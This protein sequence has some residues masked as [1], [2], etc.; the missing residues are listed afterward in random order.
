VRITWTILEPM[1]FRRNRIGALNSCLDAISDDQPA[2][3]WSE[4]ALMALRLAA[5]AF[6]LMAGVA[7][8]QTAGARGAFGSQ[9]LAFSPA[10]AAKQLDL[11]NAAAAGLAPQRPGRADVYVLA[12][13][14]WDD[15]VF[16]HEASEAANVLSRRFGAQGRTLV[17]SAGVSG[18]ERTLPA[19]TPF[20]IGA[21][22]SKIASRMDLEEDALVLFMTSHGSRDGAIALHEQRRLRATLSGRQ[23]RGLLDGVGVKNRVVIVSACFSGAFVAPLANDTSIILTAA[24]STQSSFGCQP[25]RDWTYFGDAF[26]NQ[27]LGSGLPLLE[28]FDRAKVTIAGWEQRDGYEPS[29]PQRSVGAATGPLLSALSRIE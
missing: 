21:A 19:A 9:E 23:L 25:E 7:Q 15:H 20:F 3:T 10:D 11:F 6:V 2:S 8:A 22:L 13:G 24:S 14:L 5:V 1:P 27:A 18:Q 28:A 4:I 12:L 26:I 17:L 16:Q 29:N